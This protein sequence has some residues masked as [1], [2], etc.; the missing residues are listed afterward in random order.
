[1]VY[2]DVFYHDI[3]RH[4]TV[5]VLYLFAIETQPKIGLLILKLSI[6][7]EESAD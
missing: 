6:L 2:D 5:Y 7:R 1:M 3:S 4:P